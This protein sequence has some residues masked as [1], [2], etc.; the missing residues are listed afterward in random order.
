MKNQ[1]SKLSIAIALLFEIILIGTAIINIATREWKDLFLTLLAMVC[2]TLP[3]LITRIANIKSITLPPRFQLITLLFIVMAQYL[4]EIVRFYQIFWWWDLLL[5]AIFGSY[6]VI[7]ALHSIKGTIQKEQ[8]TTEQRFALFSVIFAFSLSIALGTLWEMVEFAGDY[9]FNTNM[10][11]GGLEDTSSDLIV[12]I[13]AAFITSV[14]CY[15]RCLKEGS[16]LVKIIS[17]NDN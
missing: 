17:T 14:I 13:F 7:F 9:L 1:N 6:A 4:G 2:L 3:F 16:S 8:Q 15:N 12:K 11:K 10:V 5:H